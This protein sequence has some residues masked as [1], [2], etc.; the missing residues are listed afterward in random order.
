M[1]FI[2]ITIIIING[3]V[4]WFTHVQRAFPLNGGGGGG[5]EGMGLTNDHN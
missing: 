4:S 1:L 2:I 5:G 3:K